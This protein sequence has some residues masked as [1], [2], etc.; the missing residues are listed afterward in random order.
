MEFENPL[1]SR[2]AGPAMLRAWSRDA[3]YVSWRR[4]WIALADEQR[5]LGLKITPEQVAELEAGLEPVPYARVREIEKQTRHDVMAHVLAWCEQCPGAAGIVHLGATSAYVT[6]NADLIQLREGMRILYAGLLDAIEAFS[7]FA[8]RNAA[9]PTLGFTHFQPAQPTTIGK[10]ACMWIQDM[11]FDAV[12]LERRIEGLPFLGVKGTTGT[13]ASFLQLFDGN[14]GKVVALDRAVAGRFGFQ[15]L[16]PISGQT[17]TRKL[18]QQV[19][20]VLSGIA[21]TAS[22]L[23]HDLRLLQHLGELEEPF[24][25]G[26]VGSSAMPYKRNPILSERICGLARFAL[27]L[28]QNPPLTAASQWLERS[29]DDSSNRRLVLPQAFLTCD[30]IVRAL[31]AIGRG[32]TVYPE[33]VQAHLDVELPFLASESF[34]MAASEK[35]ESRQDA[36]EVIRELAHQA[37]GRVRRGESNDLLERLAADPRLPLNAEE[38]KTLAE[39]KRF[40][41]RA[42]E[43]VFGFLDFQIQPYLAERNHL[44]AKTT[45]PEV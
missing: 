30:G 34:L 4:L 42:A 32:L 41:G 44:Q 10:R 40:T 38:L 19:L 29:L 36:H 27:T 24:G 12:D 35:G 5:K 15:N 26:Q 8:R 23:A 22:K 43:Q 13:Q 3:K 39:P 45:A 16:L 28:C 6:D 11:L 25:K 7:G 1:I 18:D 2:Y 14:H 33:V 17:Y 21:V 20:D 31:V 9:V 37:R